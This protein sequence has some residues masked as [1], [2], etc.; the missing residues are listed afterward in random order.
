MRTFIWIRHLATG[1]PLLVALTLSVAVMAPANSDTKPGAH[2]AVVGHASAPRVSPPSAGV[3]LLEDIL[4]RMRSLPQI[5]MKKNTQAIAYQQTFQSPVQQQGPTNPTLTI[6]PPQQKGDKSLISWAP[7]NARNLSARDSEGTELRADKGESSPAAARQKAKSTLAYNSVKEYSE[8]GSTGAQAGGGRYRLTPT[9]YKQTAGKAMPAPAAGYLGGGGG[10]PADAIIANARPSE[11]KAKDSER[12]EGW[13]RLQNSVGN[14]YGTL[15]KMQEAQQIA[16]VPKS[17]PLSGSP[18]RIEASYS[19]D[20]LQDFASARSSKSRIISSKPLITEYNEQQ[21]LAMGRAVGDEMSQSNAPRLSGA[22]NGTIGPQ[23]ADANFIRPAQSPPFFN[24]IREFFG[25]QQA[26]PEEEAGASAAQSPIAKQPQSRKT[27]QID[28]LEGDRARQIELALLPPSVVTGIPV[29]R[30]GYSE[31]EAGKALSSMGA[32]N[33]TTING[34]SVWSL[35]K[36]GDRNSAL[37]VYMRNG[38]VEAIRIFD[39][40]LIAPD[41]GV[42]LGDDLATVKQKF[43]EPS[44]MIPE[45]TSGSEKNYVYPIS[46]VSFQMAR[47]R[48]QAKPQVVSLLIFNAK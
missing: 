8:T 48:N 31:S 41:F 20:R 17:S 29:M 12:S 27:A 4:S 43:G 47:L 25:G 39:P 6:K 15:N 40:S 28:S 10:A 14:L 5:A 9:A 22:T 11:A 37:Q 38:M 35:Q 2:L 34:W 7:E 1:A 44:F 19:D 18:R 26:Q 24:N 45:P 32:V 30:L 13:R 3:K 33:R 46:Q 42:K 21:K 23:G 36:P 16:Q